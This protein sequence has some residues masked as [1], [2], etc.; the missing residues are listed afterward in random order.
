VTNRSRHHFLTSL[1]ARHAKIDGLFLKLLL[2]QWALTLVIAVAFGM[3]TWAG[4]QSSLHFHI[5]LVVVFGAVINA[6]PIALIRLRPGWWGTR[7]AIAIAQILWSAMLITVT[8]GRIETHFHIFG[9]LAFL[10]FYRDWRVLVTATVVVAVDHLLRGLVAPTSVYG[11]VDPEWWRFLEH[12]GWVAFEVGV[13]AVG[14]RHGVIEM[15][16]FADREAKLAQINEDIE[17]RVVERTAELVVANESL[18]REMQARLQTEAELR[19]AQK[20]ESVGR[21]AAGVAHEINTPVQFVSDSIHFLRDATTDLLAAADKLDGPT[22]EAADFAYLREAVP[23]AIERSL[24]GLQRVATIVRS[25]RNFAHPDGA[26]PT[27][28]DLNAAIESTL[29]IAKSEYKYVADVELGRGDVPFV[30][31]FG[32]DINQA[33]LNIIVNAAHAI[34]DRVAGTGTRGVIAIATVRD[35]DHVKITISDTGTGIPATIRDR[36]FDPFFTTKAVGKGTG[37]GL[38][39]VRSIV[40]DKH[41]GSIDVASEVGKG[42]TF[43]LR[44]PIDAT[45]TRRAA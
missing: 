39:I 26:S 40:V 8:G 12:A 16:R 2:G 10:A 28:V 30:D 33:L 36:I 38:A 34:A 45:S 25:M 42:T 32:G 27:S 13:L 6:L 9:S 20:L 11:I 15:Q 5:K 1:R 23:G 7:H 43:T 4:A 18:G 44:L 17:R 35:G 22:K 41:G 31:C 3:H 19:Q 24:L 29:A 21:L 37:Q 14:C